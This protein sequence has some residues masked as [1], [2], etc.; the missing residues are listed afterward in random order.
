MMKKFIDKIIVKRRHLIFEENDMIKVLKTV[1]KIHDRGW[2][3]NNVAI[4]NCGWDDRAKW[5]IHFDASNERWEQIKN[6]LNVKRVWNNTDIPE[7]STGVVY[8]TD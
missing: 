3:R 2:L 1:D 4:G 6:D 8:S 7:K 5:F